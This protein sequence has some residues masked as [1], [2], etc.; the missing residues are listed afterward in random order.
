MFELL[1]KLCIKIAC[2]GLNSTYIDR[3]YAD[4][5]MMIIKIISPFIVA[6]ECLLA[7]NHVECNELATVLKQ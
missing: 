5:H 1:R 6:S 2:N 4:K 3:F 7:Q